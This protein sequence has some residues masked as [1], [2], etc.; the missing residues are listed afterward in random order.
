M[1]LAKDTLP[2]TMEALIG[3][4]LRASRPLVADRSDES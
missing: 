3:A 2:L 1:N 4:R